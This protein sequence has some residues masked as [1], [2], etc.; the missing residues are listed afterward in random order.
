[1]DKKAQ[2]AQK[3]LLKRVRELEQWREFCQGEAR[4]AVTDP[5]D[6]GRDV[7]LD[8]IVGPVDPVGPVEGLRRDHDTKDRTKPEDTGIASATIKDS[9][10]LR[11]LLQ[12]LVT[13]L[14]LQV[15]ALQGQVKKLESYRD[16][17]DTQLQ[18]ILERLTALE[19]RAE[20]A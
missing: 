4:A 7:A 1:M 10:D 13:P 8:A 11:A 20:Q 18:T 2:L 15:E 3:D 14:A 19:A 5:T 16:A 6:P 12:A 9:P 17:H